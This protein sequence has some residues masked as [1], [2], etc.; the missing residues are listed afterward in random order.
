MNF[1]RMPRKPLSKEEL[2]ASRE[3]DM[4]A[5]SY[6]AQ[7][8]QEEKKEVMEKREREPE[9]E[10]TAKDIEEAETPARGTAPTKKPSWKHEEKE[11]SPEELQ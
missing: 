1:D 2:A 6:E 11:F 9:V 8:E 10:F 7:K 3:T 5:A 4:R